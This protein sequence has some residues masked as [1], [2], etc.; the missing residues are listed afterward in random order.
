MTADC[1]LSEGK[2]DHLTVQV[3]WLHNLGKKPLWECILSTGTLNG[4]FHE[5]LAAWDY[6]CLHFPKDSLLLWML[7]LMGFPEM[8]WSEL[9]SCGTPTYKGSEVFSPNF[10]STIFH[11]PMEQ[12][13]FD[14][15]HAPVI[16][17]DLPG[18]RDLSA[19]WQESWEVSG[20]LFVC[21]CCFLI[22]TCN[23]V[24]PTNTYC[25]Y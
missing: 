16:G 7:Y 12:F 13:I 1:A 15:Q 14:H 21:Y 20:F 10:F 18:S 25:W 24:I 11:I 17:R 2:G 8:G 5:V 22:D 3:L 9:H 19:A 23:R 4:A 6:T